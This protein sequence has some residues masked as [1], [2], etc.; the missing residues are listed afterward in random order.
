MGDEPLVLAQR[1]VKGDP[2]PEDAHEVA[3]PKRPAG[4]QP[5]KVGFLGAHEAVGEE[6]ILARE[7]SGRGVEPHLKVVRVPEDGHRRRVHGAAARRASAG[8]CR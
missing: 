4:L 5:V 8:R 6:G 3:R 1:P 2:V 7:R